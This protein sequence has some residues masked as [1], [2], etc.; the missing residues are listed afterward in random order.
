MKLITVV[1]S[2]MFLI[3]EGLLSHPQHE[4]AKKQMR[5]FSGM[6]TFYIK[7]GLKEASDFLKN[8]KVCIS[9]L[10]DIEIFG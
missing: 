3:F 7:G 1:D 4:L 10:S 2:V 5:G 9:Y 6:V 8:V